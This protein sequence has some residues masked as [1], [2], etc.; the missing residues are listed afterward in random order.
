MPPATKPS[1]RAA[2]FYAGES[3]DM[4][5]SMGHLLFH[6]MLNMK[7]EIESRMADV[8][9]TDAQWKPLWMIKTGR[10]DTAFELAREMSIDAGAMTR[11]LDRLTAK[12][13]VERVRSE[14]D[15]RVVHLKLTREGEAA[16]EHV[17]HVLAA[18][19]NDFLR[20]F[21]K[22][23]WTTLKEYLQRMLVNGDALQQQEEEVQ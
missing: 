6:L 22:Q 17:P 4:K 1:R 23:E 3:Y 15:R 21:N 13:L 19:N 18:V 12:G 7:R 11:M 10:A 16:A 20:G 8:G 14:T 2:C 5:D 9:L